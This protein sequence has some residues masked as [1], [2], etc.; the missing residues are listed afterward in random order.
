MN[1][2]SQTIL[3]QAAERIPIWD[4]ALLDEWTVPF[5][6]WMEQASRWI[7]NNLEVLLDALAWPFELMVRNLVRDFLI[8]ISWVWIV[9]AMALVAWLTRNLKVAA[10]VAAALTL[11]GLLG[12][13]FWKETAATIGLIGVAVILCVVIG[14][15]VGIAC[16]RVDGIWQVTRP[17]LDAMQVVHSFVYM[18]PFIW[19]FGL[20]E[21]SATMVTMVYALPPL[22]RL[23]NLGI[24]QVP[25]DVVEA[26]RAY[27]ASEARVLFDVQIPLARPAIMTGINQTLLLAISMLGVAALMGAIGL[28]RVLFRAI[29]NQDVAEGAAGGLAFFLVA[30]VLDRMSQREGTASTTLLRRVQLAWKHRRDP[31]VLMPDTKPSAVVKYQEPEEYAPVATGERFPMLLALI[32]GVATVVSPFLPWTSDAGK[33]SAWGRWADASLGGELD[34]Q[35]FDGLSAS[36]GSWFGITLLALGLFIVLAV[37]TFAAR[38]GLAPRW[39]AADGTVIAAISTLVISS[40]HL[41]T[42]SVTDAGIAGG[43]VDPGNGIGVYLAIAGGVAASTGAILWMRVAEHSPL[44]PLPLGISWGRIIGLGIGIL[45]LLLGVFSGWSADSRPDRALTAEAVAEAEA[46]TLEIE[47]LKRRSDEDPA[48]SA[49]YAADLLVLEAQA[50]QPSFTNG[51]TNSGPQLG[52]WTLIAGLLAMLTGLPAAG[53]FGGDE[54]RRWRWST[55]TAGL[56]GGVTCIAFAWIFTHVRSGDMQFLTGIGAF[57]TLVSGLLIVASTMAVLKEFRRSKV[58]GDP[59]DSNSEADATVKAAVGTRA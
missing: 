14:I 5:G 22:I 46:R 30:V 55:V 3:A 1:P 29:N 45:T 35:T 49:V 54:Q 51:L 42:Q 53:V 11:C 33:I 39:L 50:R 58:Y 26:S 44:H 43:A 13:E 24:R 36:G 48:N 16:G 7:A 6:D 12:D 27:G 10:F 47:E 37:I 31:E 38:P 17:I 32:G 15:P 4:N 40:A 9:L 59:L 57:L 20:G 19:F 56:G 28:G 2:P 21:V 23:T 34:G 18:L 52:I 25:S 8:E 41:L